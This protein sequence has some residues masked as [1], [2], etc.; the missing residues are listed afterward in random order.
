[1]AHSHQHFFSVILISSASPAMPASS[2][3][4][5]YALSFHPHP[6]RSL[7]FVHSFIND[8]IN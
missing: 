3:A 5:L 8:I 7:P 2:S 4:L 1:M 6:R